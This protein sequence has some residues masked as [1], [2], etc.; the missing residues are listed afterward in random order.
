MQYKTM[1]ID[2]PIIK[3]KSGG[4]NYR[5]IDGLQF[6]KK[7]EAAIWEKQAEGFEFVDMHPIT[8]PK[9]SEKVMSYSITTGMIL[10]FRK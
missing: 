2:A 4:I 5:E 9:P 10:N 8:S 7:I 6:S 1:F 3:V